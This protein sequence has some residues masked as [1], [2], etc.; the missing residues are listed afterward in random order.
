MPAVRAADCGDA[1]S[2]RTGCEPIENLGADRPALGPAIGGGG[3]A[4]LSGN[5]QNQPR[6][7]RGGLGQPMIEPDMSGIERMAV[8]IER[9]IRM[10]RRA[11]KLLVP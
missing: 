2:M 1:I 3:A 7:H 11:R 4:R 8:E 9:K 10:K 6:A 5:H